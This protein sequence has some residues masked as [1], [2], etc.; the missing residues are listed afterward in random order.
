MTESAK[1]KWD[2]RYS[3]GDYKPRN[4]PSPFLE[5]WLPLIPVGR[6][7]DIACGA[8]RNALRLAEAGFKVDAVDISSVALEMAEAEAGKRGLAVNWRQADLSKFSGEKSAYNLITV[9]RFKE[10]GLWPKLLSSL[11]ADGWIIIEHHLL[12]TK[13]VGGPTDANFRIKPG[14]L[15]QAFKGLRILH[16]T[17]TVESE[18][19][20]ALANVRIA[21]C[22]GSPGW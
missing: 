4:K 10:A 1:A 7:L 2:S 21:A 3:A 9:F 18:R 14:E 12:T 19:G 20:E 16:Y 22:N 13:D 6:A 17:E 8:G 5:Q 11:S 15:L